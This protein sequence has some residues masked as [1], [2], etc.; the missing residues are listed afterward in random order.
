MAVTAVAFTY[1]WAEMQRT[2]RGRGT[3]R[4]KARHASV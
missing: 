2:A 3:D 1:Q 4:P